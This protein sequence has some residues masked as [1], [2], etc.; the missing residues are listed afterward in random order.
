M[1]VTS[2]ASIEHLVGLPI[3]ARTSRKA[4][5]AGSRL[6]I[7][8]PQIRLKFSVYH[9]PDNRPR[10]SKSV[11]RTVW[12]LFYVTD[13]IVDLVRITPSESAIFHDTECAIL[14]FV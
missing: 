13:A 9:A 8:R 12:D 10:C 11:P 7:C 3:V 2:K 1:S 14:Q 4:M 6:A 5:E